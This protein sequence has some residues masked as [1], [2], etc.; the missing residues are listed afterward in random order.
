MVFYEV[1]T[2]APSQSL[3]A[4][5]CHMCFELLSTL[6]QLSI[7]VNG[8]LYF[9]TSDACS[10][11]TPPSSFLPCT[12]LQRNCYSYGVW[13]QTQL[14]HQQ[15]ARKK[16]LQ[17]CPGRH[18][19]DLDIDFAALQLERRL[20]LLVPAEVGVVPCLHISVVCAQLDKIAWY[21]VLFGLGRLHGA[22]AHAKSCQISVKALAP[23]LWKLPIL[24]APR[25]W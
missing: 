19:C 7:R 8:K 10:T 1:I 13:N 3:Y 5:P 21:V 22:V 4:S 2:S 12:N 20:G 11:C 14:R 6:E 9:E 17:V 18:L 23:N 25:P 15:Q 16:P 24:P